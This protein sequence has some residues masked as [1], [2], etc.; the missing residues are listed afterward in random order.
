MHKLANTMQATIFVV[1]SVF[2]ILAC[3]QSGRSGEADA[4]SVRLRPSI[5]TAKMRPDGTIRLHLTAP[6]RPASQEGLFP[7][8]WSPPQEHLGYGEVELT[9]G[10]PHHADILRHLGG[11]K[12]GETKPVPPWQHSEKWH[13]AID[14]DRGSCP[15]VHALRV[16]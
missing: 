9:P 13:C 15:L 11:L 14:P 4:A 1:A 2:A 7:V 5:G 12:S 10:D 16:D 6:S 8:P 3:P